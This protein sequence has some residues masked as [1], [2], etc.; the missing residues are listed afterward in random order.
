MKEQKEQQEVFTGAAAADFSGKVLPVKERGKIHD[1]WVMKRLKTVL[2]GLMEREGI[3]MWVMPCREHNED[4]VLL[5]ML[6]SRMDSAR[7]RTILVFYRKEDG[8]VERMAIIRPNTGIDTIYDGEPFYTNM[9]VNQKGA[10]WSGAAKLMS[11][12]KDNDKSMPPETEYECLAR[13]VRERKP[14]KIGLNFSFINAY[15]DGITMTEYK[16]VVN[17]LD[18]EYKDRIVTAEKLAIGWLETRLDEEIYAYNGIMQVNHGV[19]AEALSPRVIHPCVT[20][21]EDVSWWIKNKFKSLGFDR[22]G[23]QV[24]IYRRTE[25]GVKNFI[26][27]ETI[28]PG[29]IVHCDVGFTYLDMNC[30]TQWNAYVLKWDEQELPE[31]LNELMRA[32]NRVEDIFAENLKAGRTGNEV[33]K[34]IRDKATAEGIKCRIFA[35]PIGLHGHAAGPTIGLSD[36]QNGVPGNGDLVVYD[37]TCYS[38]ELSITRPIP[39]WGDFQMGFETNVAFHKGE[40]Y[41][42]GGRQT[43]FN[44]I[45]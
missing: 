34:S 21:A 6:P 31:E 10:D 11:W 41:Y 5:T 13:L 23:G 1:R 9:W 26:G 29:D 24:H 4:P 15:A 45:K 35:H 43:K 14:K 40:V 36:Q 28:L 3:D 17:C 25:N 16:N 19:I 30:D 7:R 38:M 27:A 2:P 32:G 18:E 37:N 12:L 33:L 39:G 22:G 20:T 44:L 42:L 8:T